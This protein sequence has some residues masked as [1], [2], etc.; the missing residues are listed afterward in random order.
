MDFILYNEA[1]KKSVAVEVDGSYHFLDNQYGNLYSQEHI[2]RIETLT[3]AGWK[4]IN[5]PYYK[6][7]K[8]GWLCDE[9]NE[10][11][12]AELRRIYSELDKYIL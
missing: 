10:I 5:T 7:Y 6:W 2:E 9:N 8:D 3:R 12:N 11:F 4:I 1:N